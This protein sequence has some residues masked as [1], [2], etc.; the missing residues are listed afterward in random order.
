MEKQKHYFYGHEISDYGVKNGYVDYRTLASCF[1]CI[2]NN[3]IMKKTYD[4]GYWEQIHGFIDNSEKINENENKINSLEDVKDWLKD[5]YET[6]TNK[7]LIDKLID[8][9]DDKQNELQDDNNELEREQDEQPE[10]FQ[11]YIVSDAG[12]DIL[13]RET[14]EIL[15][16][17]DELDMYIWGVTHWGT[18]WD[19]VL[20]DINI[21]Q[22]EK[23]WK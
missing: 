13:K 16:Y 2:L 23:R 3:D 4:I 7:N 21:E 17:N 5:K 9:A 10:I 6:A 8:R 14:N 15:F 20:T 18:S 1:D 12:A 22:F 19:Y 11:Y